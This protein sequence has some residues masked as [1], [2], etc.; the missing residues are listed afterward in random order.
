[1]FEV[2]VL[3]KHLMDALNIL[4]PTVGNNSQNLGD[5]CLSIEATNAG[6]VIMY[7]TNTIE[8]SRLELIVG[9]SNNQAGMAPYVDFKR[10]MNLVKTI[11]ETE[12][13]TIKQDGTN[14]ITLE[15]QLKKQPIKLTGCNNGMIPLP[16]NQQY[17]P[18]VEVPYDFLKEALDG[19]TSIIKDSE[20]TP[21]YNC[22]RIYTDGPTIEVSGL[23]AATRRMFMAEGTAT[24]HNPTC[25]T[26]VEA[27]KLA[28][29]LKLFTDYQEVVFESSGAVVHV[30]GGTQKTGAAQK[31]GHISNVEYY[32]RLISGVYPPN[33]AQPIR[34]GSHEYVEINRDDLMA[35]IARAKALEDTSIGQRTIQFDVI[36]SKVKVVLSSAFGSLEDEFNAIS[37]VKKQIHS[38][39]KYEYLSDIIK[40]ITTD[41]VEIGS[42]PG[43]NGH[44]IVKPAGRTDMG[45][46]IAE[47]VTAQS[48]TP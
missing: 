24:N 8:F 39:F 31:M 9:S 16:S 10:F 4:A 41:T 13:I 37:A 14:D 2:T 3:Q 23:D 20:S 25:Q 42:L 33:I 18:Q 1:M 29:S 43:Y 6:S 22:V 34:A 40:T 44:Y 35:A 12:H 36:G 11:P 15:F 32:T 7:T 45:F 30:S 47:V 27:S 5:N 46:T 21:I 38:I 28:K 26:L 19:A 48:S 17:Q